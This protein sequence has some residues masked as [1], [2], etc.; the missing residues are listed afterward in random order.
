MQKRKRR[1]NV[2]SEVRKKG[3]YRTNY[4]QTAKDEMQVLSVIGHDPLE[5]YSQI[6]KDLILIETRGIK[7]TDA[8]SSR[9]NEKEQ[10]TDRRTHS[11]NQN[12]S[13][14]GGVPIC[15]GMQIWDAN[16]HPLSQ[17]FGGRRC[18]GFLT[19]RAVAAAEEME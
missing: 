7:R 8:N 1:K 14:E 6:V 9:K 12:V 11:M 17:R 18:S 3:G 10:Q 15:A 19:H 4:V 2:G 5:K 13:D 16:I